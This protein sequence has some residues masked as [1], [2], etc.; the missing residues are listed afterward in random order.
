[1]RAT[2]KDIAKATG[3]AVSTVA[4]ILNNNRTCFAFEAARKAIHDAARR[5][6]YRPHFL[7]R[8]LRRQRSALIGIVGSLFGSVVVGQ[9]FA[10]FTER[11]KEAGY[12]GL[13]ADTRSH[14]ANERE[15]LVEIGPPPGGG[16]SLSHDPRDRDG[17]RDAAA[18][19][20]VRRGRAGAGS[21]RAQH[22]D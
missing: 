10:S 8:S 5:L 2:L 20:P 13:L 15:A 18:R 19:H 4:N 16:D 21:R 9:Q 3:Y 14:P 11:L 22:R 1:M 12:M 6:G 17:P 7:A